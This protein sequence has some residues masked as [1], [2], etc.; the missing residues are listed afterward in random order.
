MPHR[1]IRRR[2]RG[3]PL[4]CLVITI[5]ILIAGLWPFNFL[6]KNEVT[7]LTGRNGI[8]FGPLGIAY[9]TD[10]IYGAHGAIL[11]GRP[12]SIE[13]VVQ[14]AGKIDAPFSRIL[15]LYEGEKNLEFFT[16]AQWKSHLILRASSEGKDL[17]IG[18]PELGVKNVFLKNIPMFLTITSNN[19]ITKIYADGRMIIE[20]NNF[21]IL[22]G[23]SSSSGKFVLGNSS[24]GKSP[25]TGNLLFLT[26]YDRELPAEEI[27][28][29]FHDWIEHGAPT[30]LPGKTPPILYLFDERTGS[31]SRNHRGEHLDISIPPTF[32][33]LQK[34][35]LRLPWEEEY[36]HRSFIRDVVINILGFLPF[37]FFFA[38]WLRNGD[39]LPSKSD[40]LRVAT[41]GGG[42]SLFIELLQISLPT[43][44]SSLSDIICNLFGTILGVLLFR[45]IIPFL[46][47][48]KR[49]K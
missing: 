34:T 4:I 15:T 1:N 49:T 47:I 30:W 13:L 41:L 44:T 24:T 33:L 18:S 40:L 45:W 7:W 2:K 16:L 20:H 10:S 29:H 12:V 28:K 37:G 46:G 5:A 48:E 38:M 42:I 25:W 31:I 9:S 3:V 14:Q 43:R 27:I 32:H 39:G 22:P 6:P 36:F 11:P 17:R 8:Y 19:G 23:D 21:P 26:A 35:V